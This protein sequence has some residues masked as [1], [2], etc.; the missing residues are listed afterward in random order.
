MTVPASVPATTALDKATF[1]ERLNARREMSGA[2]V[3]LDDAVTA[4]VMARAGFDFIT[5]DLQHSYSTMSAAD[6]LVEAVRQGGAPAIVRVPWNTPDLIMR[7]LDLGADGVIVP[8]VNSAAEAE[9]AASACHYAPRGT[10]SWGPLWQGVHESFPD[11]EEGDRAAACI[12]M[13]ETAAA[14]ADID[15]IAAVPDVDAVYIGQND[16]SLSAGLGR[17]T[18]AESPQMHAMIERII[19]RSHAAGTAVGLDCGG[20]DA[21]R[22]W[23]ERGIDFVIAANDV[24]LL[25]QAAAAAAADLQ[26]R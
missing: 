22:Y 8:M 24:A 14:Y 12:V 10:R 20:A 19:E 1:R 2:W 7:S 16:L 5:I 15:A 11:H 4:Q 23:R 6:A 21:A 3:F 9:A 26:K 13:I 25:G 17:Q 18:Y